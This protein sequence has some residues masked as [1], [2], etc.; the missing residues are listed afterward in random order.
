M[1]F[2]KF[3]Y[4]YIFEVSNQHCCCIETQI[5]GNKFSLPSTLLLP[6]LPLLRGSWT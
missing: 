3:I 5:I 2:Y 1:I 6:P 4:A